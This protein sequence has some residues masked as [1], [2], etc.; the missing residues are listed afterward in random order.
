MTGSRK[1]HVRTDERGQQGKG[2]M[3]KS[4]EGTIA[5]SVLVAEGRSAPDMGISMKRGLGST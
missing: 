4:N 1:H 5:L 3:S 2:A